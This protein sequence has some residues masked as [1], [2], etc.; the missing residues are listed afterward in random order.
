AKQCLDIV[1][2]EDRDPEEIV[3]TN[4]WEQLTDPARISA[5]AEAVF[6][7]ESA[8]VTELRGILAV[9]AKQVGGAGSK[10]KRR[11]TLTAYLVGKVIAATSGRADPKLAGQQ[12]E[13]LLKG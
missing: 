4:N 5:L 8:T 10:E 9:G 13:L 12:V 2:A 7:A 3:K 11:R 6:A 1:I